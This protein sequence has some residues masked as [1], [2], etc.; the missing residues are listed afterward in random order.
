MLNT[1]AFS[2]FTFS[3]PSD[4]VNYDKFDDS[5]LPVS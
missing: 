4:S 3:F 1:A 5:I 2:F